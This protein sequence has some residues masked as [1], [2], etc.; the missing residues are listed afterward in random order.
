LTRISR[1]NDEIMN[2]REYK[3]MIERHIS[4]QM[5]VGWNVLWQ[6]SKV[7]LIL[8]ITLAF[9]IWGLSIDDSFIL[10]MKR[11]LISLVFFWFY[12]LNGTKYKIEF[13]YNNY[14]II[15]WFLHGILITVENVKPDN[16]EPFDAWLFNFL[17][18]FMLMF[19]YWFKWKKFIVWFW[20]QKIIYF[21]A[22]YYKY[23]GNLK[24][25]NMF[26]QVIV[27]LLMPAFSIILLKIMLNF[28][29]AAHQNKNLANSIKNI[30]QVFPEWVIIRDTLKNW[31]TETVFV[32][33]EAAHELYE[34]KNLEV[35][36]LNEKEDNEEEKLDKIHL[37]NLLSRQENKFYKKNYIFQPKESENIRIDYS[38]FQHTKASET[39][40]YTLNTIRVTWAH[41]SQAFMHVF[42]NTTNIHKLE[43]EKATNKW[44]HIMFSSISHELRTPINAFFNANEMIKFGLNIIKESIDGDHIKNMANVKRMV[45]IIDKNVK[46]A[47]VSSDLLLSLTEDILDFA[48]IEAGIFLLNP[49]KFRISSLLEDI[50][51]IFTHQWEF[52]GIEFRIEWE[53]DLLKSKFLSDFGRIKQ[54]LRNL[55]SNAFK[56]TNKGHIL[57][58]IDSYK[59]R[60]FISSHR[61]LKFDIEDT[62]IGISEQDQTWLFKI[63]GIAHEHRDEFNCRGTGLGLTITQKLVKM[64]EGDIS[65][66]SEENKGT[67][68][69]FT[70]K[71]SQ[72]NENE[73]DQF[74]DSELRKQSSVSIVA[75]ISKEGVQRT[76]RFPLNSDFHHDRNN[77]FLK[78]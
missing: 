31:D 61:Y 74:H 69:T 47:S 65:L 57:L 21:I 32:N 39:R 17:L 25:M 37:E 48:K 1:E 66:S 15:N 33:N 70:I 10:I 64:F 53:E 24:P 9:L 23:G 40:F 45:E 38:P 14:F 55:I 67:Q 60:S 7:M 11:I 59:E 43:K 68:V 22:M 51:S 3:K 27:M 30:L 72:R 13:I 62:G 26:Y 5:K 12:S 78:K 18:L 41:S 42:V 52:K 56:F 8:N 20:I 35:S 44:M 50:Q 75:Q 54:I 6:V 63:F 71:E 2:N 29:V 19:I 46:I 77:P 4:L 34:E 16:P 76:P 49:Q 28:M 58:K 36:I 73:I